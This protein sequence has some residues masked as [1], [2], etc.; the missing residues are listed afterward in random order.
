M[1][2]KGFG[3]GRAGCKASSAIDESVTFGT[4]KLDFNGFWENPCK[5]CKDS[6]ELENKIIAEHQYKPQKTILLGG[7]KQWLDWV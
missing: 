2:K 7:P 5:K 6:W 3:C 4:G 1:A